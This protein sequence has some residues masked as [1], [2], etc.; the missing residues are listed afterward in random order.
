[1]KLCYL[2]NIWN[3]VSIPK[4]DEEKVLNA[5]KEGKLKEH[6]DLYD[7]MDCLDLE[8]FADYDSAE[9]IMPSRKNEVTLKLIEYEKIDGCTREHTIIDNRY[10]P[11]LKTIVV[12]NDRTIYEVEAETEEEA[13]L[14]VMRNELR[15]KAYEKVVLKCKVC[16]EEYEACE[17]FTC[18]L[19]HAEV[20]SKCCND[21]I[22]CKGCE[23]KKKEEE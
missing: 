21:D 23:S 19:C 11:A 10:T 3:E 5:F 7:I 20:C 16:E 22:I 18:D 8:T 1:M 9:D 15:F 4:E 12:T 6:G 14:A 13:M 2:E 17:L